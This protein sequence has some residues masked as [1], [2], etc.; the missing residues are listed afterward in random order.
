MDNLEM[1]LKILPL[2]HS[3]KEK[4]CSVKDE[5]NLKYQRR[6]HSTWYIGSLPPLTAE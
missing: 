6:V 4:F 3:K 5:L 1:P 2:H